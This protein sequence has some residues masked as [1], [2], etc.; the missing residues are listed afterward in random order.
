MPSCVRPFLLCISIFLLTA[1][2]G[3]KASAK[4]IFLI[5]MV[6]M[7]NKKDAA[8]LETLAQSFRN[9]LRPLLDDFTVDELYFV[10]IDLNGNGIEEFIVLAGS[11]AACGNMPECPASI[12]TETKKGWRFIGDI[13]AYGRHGNFAW[14]ITVEDTWSNGWR[15]LHDKKYRYCWFNETDPKRAYYD[16]DILG[17]PLEPGQAG[18]FWSVGIDETCPEKD[19]HFKQ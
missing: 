8:F 12:Y 5:N 3:G 14:I 10:R 9:T 18:Y 15:T 19:P 6:D 2:G 16:N 1:G 17:M 13:S 7:V 4:E 11:T